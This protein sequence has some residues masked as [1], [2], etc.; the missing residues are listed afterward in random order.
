MSASMPPIVRNA[1]AALCAGVGSDS[2]KAN[3]PLAGRRATGGAVATA[4]AL[5]P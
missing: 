2:D 1:T 4:V 3:V 5:G